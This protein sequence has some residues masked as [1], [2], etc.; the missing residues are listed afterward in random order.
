KGMGERGEKEIFDAIEKFR[1]SGSKKMIPIARATAVAAEIQEYFDACGGADHIDVVGGLRRHVS[2]VAEVR[3]VAAA[4]NARRVIDCFCSMPMVRSVKERGE[5]YASITTRYRLNAT[6]R[7]VLPDD[8]GMG[9]VI[10]TGSAAH[11]DRLKRIASE[12]G[13][14]IGPSGYYD[15]EGERVMIPTEEHLY[16]E[17]GMAYVPPDLREDDGEMEAA[18]HDTL[19]DLVTIGDIRG[20]L[21]IHT[22][23][24]D[25]T[26]SIQDMAIAARGRGYEYIAVCDHSR[27]LQVANGL[28]IDRLR[29]QMEEID[30]LNDTLEGFTVLKSSEVDILPDGSLDLPDDIL[31]ELDIV[32]GSIHTQLKQDRKTITA[33]AIKALENDHLTI[34]AHPTSRILGRREPTAIDID[35]IVEAAKDNGKVLEVNAYPDR[36]DLDDS[37]IRKAVDAGVIICINSDSH[38]AM[39]LDTLQFGIDNA[40]RGWATRARVLN[41]LSTEALLEYLDRY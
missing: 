29:D 26:G 39:D 30:R 8:Y 36:L 1:K 31:E 32:V 35:R 9:M 16:R 38:S 20:D 7:V 23:W 19:P 10:E 15:A 18:F 13:A 34:L 41:T 27:S 24:S 33:R 3:F 4:D 14:S 28:S 2:M 11:T 25:G 17:L 40:R 12:R 5:R 6:L 22:R 37:N 21:H